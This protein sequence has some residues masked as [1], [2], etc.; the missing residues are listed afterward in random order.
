MSPKFNRAFDPLRGVLE[1]VAPGVRRIVAANPG[2]Y[3]FRGTGTYVLGRG[4]VAIVDPGPNDASHIA[5]LMRQLTG[6]TVT[7]ILVTHTHPDHSPG[8]QPLRAHTTAP[9]YGFGPHPVTASVDTSNDND[10]HG[11][12]DGDPMF[13]PD[14]VTRHGDSIAGSGWRAEAIHTPGHISNHLCF[15]VELNSNKRERFV[16]TGDHVMGWST[17]VI[18][19]P[20]GNLRDYLA[21]LTLLLDDDDAR[22][23][24]THG[25]VVT[26]PHDFIRALIEHRHGRSAQILTALASPKTV[27]E[28]VTEMYRGLDPRLV[29]AAGRSVLAHLA[30][31]I[32]RGNVVEVAGDS[33]TATAYTVAH[34]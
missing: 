11:E 23:W 12:G 32:D 5:L 4:E 27:S 6:E 1:D 31:L 29:G 9:T 22:Y 3:T 33:G 18:S 20:H 30:D 17:S 19:P 24:P 10:H 2:P 14:V 13:V 34:G 7:H 15:R 28:L 26:N 8:C 21:S 25:T 16:F